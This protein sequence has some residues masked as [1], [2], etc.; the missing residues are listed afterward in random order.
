MPVKSTLA[1][2]TSHFCVLN[3]PSG[4]WRSTYL[5]ERNCSLHRTGESNPV[6]NET[7]RA[8]W[9]RWRAAERPQ[10]SATTYFVARNCRAATRSAASRR[11]NTTSINAGRMDRRLI[12]YCNCR[13]I[14]TSIAHI[15]WVKH[16]SSG[17]GAHKYPRHLPLFRQRTSAQSPR[18]HPLGSHHSRLSAFCLRPL[19]SRQ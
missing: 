6:P 16:V 12:Q 7:H 19:R 17:L 15:K 14:L 9:P 13:W 1:W 8:C 3:I 10:C 18:A 2:S 5:K 4:M 11:V